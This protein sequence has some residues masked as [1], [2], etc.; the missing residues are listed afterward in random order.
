MCSTQSLR[1]LSFLVKDAVIMGIYAFLFGLTA[2]ANLTLGI[3]F[4][5]VPAGIGMVRI[6][7]KGCEPEW[8]THKY[9]CHVY[10]NIKGV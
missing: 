7:L 1:S 8:L 10:S 2:I 6:N 5:D 4:G 9:Y 3:Q